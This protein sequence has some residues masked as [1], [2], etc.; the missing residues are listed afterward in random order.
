MSSRRGYP[1]RGSYGQPIR[2]A[3]TGY[4]SVSYTSGTS[5]NDPINRALSTNHGSVRY[6]PSTSLGHS[7]TR[8]STSYGTVN[9]TSS[10]PRGPH[11]QVLAQADSARRPR[12]MA[13]SDVL[14]SSG[15]EHSSSS[16][17]SSS[18]EEDVNRR[19]SPNSSQRRFASVQSRAGS[20]RQ[21]SPRAGRHT[22]PARRRGT[23]PP[24]R[25][26]TFRPP[27]SPEQ[28]L[29]IWFHRAD[30]DLTW[31]QVFDK[32]REQFPQA[33]REGVNGLQC[34]YYRILELHGCPRLR[35]RGR[36]SMWERMRCKYSWMDPY[37]YQLAG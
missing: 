35:G 27:Y 29:F 33:E 2:P 20:H 18:T 5:N 22:P 13:I 7:S 34:R 25:T 6:S 26:R 4:A 32:F 30:L 12:G 15:D 17:S 11:G 31:Q 1:Y 16:D 8:P 19:R 14:N 37:A 3:S 9:R 28:D 36:T 24:A 23:S 10:R 21:H